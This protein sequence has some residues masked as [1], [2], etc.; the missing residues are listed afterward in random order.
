MSD[1][2][3]KAYA[4][5]DPPI[6]R[7]HGIYPYF[8]VIDE[9]FGSEVLIDG[10]RVIMAGSNNY[11][12]LS[13]DPRVK[14]A[15]IE[16][17]KKFGSSCSGSRLLNGTL[18]LHHELEEKLAP[19]LKKEAAAVFSTGYTANLGALSALLGKED[20]VY[21]DKG[22][23][24]SIVDGVRLGIAEMKRFR[25]NTP[26]HLE[27]LVKEGDPAK[28]KMIVVDGV[29]SMEGDV[30][31]LKEIVE[32]KKK[33]NTRLF[34]DEAHGIGVFGENG[35]GTGEHFGVEDEIDLVMGT[36][37]K[38]FGSLGGVI[39]G[40]AKVIE[41][42]KH[43]ARSMIFQ[44]AMT[45]AACG[46]ALK[47]LEIIQAEPERRKNLWRNADHIRNGFTKLGFNMLHSNTPI[48]PV[49]VGDDRLAFAF[50]RALLDA[51]VFT[52]PVISPAVSPGQQ[53]IRTSFMATHTIE[54]LDRVLDIF[55]QVGRKFE[56]IGPNKRES[57]RSA[58]GSFL[59]G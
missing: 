7:A 29:F 57:H 34:V 2:F 6:A 15:A 39:A 58:A 17:I 56:I 22:D 38:S 45:P 14:E 9:T 19:F 55:D 24:G 23:H 47:S 54:Q 40:P 18:S 28:G 46:A 51:G 50:W 13:S 3:D 31:P 44:A 25:H 48:V 10:K 35:R 21:M 8:S 16:A 5:N 43:K 52:N 49:V 36:F 27:A 42:I 1:V 26:S 59:Q 30:A 32:L 41:F 53:L 37:S 4:Y 11:M 12:G 20:I 33:Y